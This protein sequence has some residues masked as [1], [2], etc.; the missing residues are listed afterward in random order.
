MFSSLEM[1]YPDTEILAT[2]ITTVRS[3]ILDQFMFKERKEKRKNVLATTKNVPFVHC[4]NYKNYHYCKV[5]G[6]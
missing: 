5:P 3:N 4:Y 6:I 2:E 1:I